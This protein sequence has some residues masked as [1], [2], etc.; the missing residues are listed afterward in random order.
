ML[1]FDVEPTEGRAGGSALLDRILARVRDTLNSLAKAVTNE[2]LVT[3]ALTT[4]PVQVRHGLKG[5][6]VTW[7]VVGRDAGEVVF[8]P[9]IINASRDR[10]VYLQAT[11]PVTVKLRFSP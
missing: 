4:S 2:R 5:S 10:F 9:A 1:P 3:A 11:G 8:E 6:P 7:E